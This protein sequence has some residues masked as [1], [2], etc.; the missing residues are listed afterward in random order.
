MGETHVSATFHLI[1]DTNR[2]GGEAVS[3]INVDTI[4]DSH[5][6]IV[7]PDGNVYEAKLAMLEKWKNLGVEKERH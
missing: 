2:M 4:V 7:M 5:V 1:F 6:K 3:N